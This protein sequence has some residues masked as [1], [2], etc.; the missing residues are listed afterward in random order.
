MNYYEIIFIIY[1]LIVLVLTIN[2][3]KLTLL[4]AN[5][6]LFAPDPRDMPQGSQN[7]QPQVQEPAGS[8]ST[9]PRCL[10]KP[11][12]SITGHRALYKAGC[13][14]CGRTVPSSPTPPCCCCCSRA[15]KDAGCDVRCRKKS[16]CI[17]THD[18]IAAKL[19]PTAL[20]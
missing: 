5:H 16:Q 12:P 4:I 6:D 7:D 1:L 11:R 8:R 3:T 13:S 2:Y 19:P 17:G 15:T 18:P 9:S 14:L 10:E 20:L